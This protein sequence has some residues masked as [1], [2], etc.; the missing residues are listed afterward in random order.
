MFNNTESKR[1][2]GSCLT[3]YRQRE[4]ESLGISQG[5]V[6]NIMGRGG[7]AKMCH[8]VYLFVSMIQAA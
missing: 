7:G 2:K 3:E 1:R 6:F 8:V 5:K 4:K